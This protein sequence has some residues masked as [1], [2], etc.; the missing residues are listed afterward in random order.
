[1]Q[2]KENFRPIAVTSVINKLLEKC[3]K[4][5]LESYLEGNNLVANTQFGFR[6]KLSTEDAILLLT[7]NVINNFND[8]FKTIGIFIDLAR[9][10]D[11]VAHPVLLKKMECIGIRGTEL[12]L[13]NSYLHQRTQQVKIG[14][15]ISNKQKIELGVPQGTVLGPILFSIYINNL[16][17]ILPKENGFIIC[18]ADDSVILIKAKSWPEVHNLA[19]KYITL[20]KLWMD[21]NLL[22]LNETKTHFIPFSM[23]NRSNVNL[24]DIT[25]HNY[26]CFKGECICNCKTTINAVKSTKYLGVYIDKNLKYNIHIEYITKKIRKTIYKFYQLREFMTKN[27]LKMIYQALVESV[28]NYGVKI[29][30]SACNTILTNLIITQKYILKIINKKPKRYPSE[31]LFKEN[32]VLTIREIYIKNVI[33][34]MI[35]NKKYKNQPAHNI[36]TRSI[37]HEHICLN[38]V[39]F[40]ICQRHISFIGPRLYNLLPIHLKLKT[41]NKKL[42]N[43]KISEWVENNFNIILSKLPCLK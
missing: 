19:E 8:G 17:N 32:K 28:L 23:N 36:N 11:T 1:M 40:T 3:V 9:A 34:Y 24:K 16:I 15:T 31:E 42:Y 37:T 10:F 4:I 7:E 13:F 29:W 2:K 26:K 30:G 21:Q 43:S 35:T 39:D 20:V 12:K 38:R 41:N 27:V 14:K 33:K 5:R 25:I 22:T 6:R 18:Y